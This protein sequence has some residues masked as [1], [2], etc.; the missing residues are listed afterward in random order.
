MPA[1]R[2]AVVLVLTAGLGLAGTGIAAARSV[3]GQTSWLVRTSGTITVLPDGTR[4]ST[5][6]VTP[7]VVTVR[8]LDRVG[9]KDRDPVPE[10][11]LWV[12]TTDAA[13]VLGRTIDDHA[14]C[15]LCDTATAEMAAALAADPSVTRVEHGSPGGL[16]AEGDAYLDRVDDD[17]WVRVRAPAGTIFYYLDA[18]HP[19]LHGSVIVGN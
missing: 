8:T 18:Y 7:A 13:K 12:F 15:G 10:P 6:A 3:P 9:W 1:I 17:V 16:D 5:L 4:T 11:H 19:W 2:V 14:P